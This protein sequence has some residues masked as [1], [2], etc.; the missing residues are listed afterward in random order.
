MASF[1]SCYAQDVSSSTTE[2]ILVVEG[3]TVLL[4]PE[5]LSDFIANNNTTSAVN[6]LKADPSLAASLTLD[7]VKAM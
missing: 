3:D 4:T 5:V 6:A 1:Y 2:N 7:Q